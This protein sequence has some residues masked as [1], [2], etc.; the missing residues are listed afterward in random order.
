MIDGIQCEF[1][2]MVQMV[3][4]LAFWIDKLSCV[5]FHL[6]LRVGFRFCSREEVKVRIVKA[7]N[8]WHNL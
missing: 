1:V 6:S 8:A 2:G 3:S 7:V 5:Y 4:Y